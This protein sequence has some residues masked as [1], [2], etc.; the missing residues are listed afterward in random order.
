MNIVI[1]LWETGKS[2]MQYIILVRKMKTTPSKM[3]IDAYG[4]HL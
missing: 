3:K 1:M 4:G 2:Q